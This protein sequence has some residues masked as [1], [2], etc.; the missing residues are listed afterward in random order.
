MVNVLL[1]HV[2]VRE[3]YVPIDVLQPGRLAKADQLIMDEAIL[4]VVELVRK[5]FALITYAEWR[6]IVRERREKR[7][8]QQKLEQQKLEQQKLEQQQAQP[9]TTTR[10]VLCCPRCQT[11]TAFKPMRGYVCGRCAF[12]F[13]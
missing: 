1:E 3:L 12:R 6:S 2:L 5:R 9:K 13:A 4:D 10:P 7:L 8:E 11:R